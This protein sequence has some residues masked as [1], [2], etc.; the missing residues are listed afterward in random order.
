MGGAKVEYKGKGGTRKRKSTY[1]F[2]VP[3]RLFP[4]GKSKA[5]FSVRTSIGG[6]ERAR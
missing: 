6:T 1:R 5:V 4:G 2:E 3:I